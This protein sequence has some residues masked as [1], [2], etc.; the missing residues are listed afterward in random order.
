[1]SSRIDVIGQNGN[2]GLH[3]NSD[4]NGQCRTNAEHIERHA[5]GLGCMGDQFVKH[6]SAK[7]KFSLIPP[8]C[9]IELA[10]HVS[11]GA[12]KYKPDNWKKVDSVDRYYDALMRHIEAW[13]SGETYDEDGKI[14][15]VAVFT[16]A[17]FLLWFELKKLKSDHRDHDY[18]ES[19][20]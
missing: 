20:Q 14:H 7:I 9:L 10:K 18:F 13:R 3:Y 6:D 16:N 11:Y 15:L 1:M 19:K 8:E 4:C 2:D 5:N 12:K 17:C